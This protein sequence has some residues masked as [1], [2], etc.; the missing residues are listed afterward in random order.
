MFLVIDSPLEN[1][2][3]SVEFVG[4]YT[5]FQFSYRL[6]FVQHLLGFYAS[7]AIVCSYV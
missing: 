5:V 7:C 4:M 1:C 3:F 2:V 6:R